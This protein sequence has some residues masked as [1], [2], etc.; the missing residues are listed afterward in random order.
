MKITG[1]HRRYVDLAKKLA[2]SSSYSLHRHGAVLVKGGSVLNWSANQNKVQR[3]AQRFRSH[4]CGHA[5]HHA[6]LGA[7]L[8]VARDKTT[9]SDVYVVRISKKGSLLMSKPCEMC[10]EL[11]RHVGVKRVFYSIDDET[12]GCYKV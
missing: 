1:R 6:E 7:V 3:W 12:M 8:G 9:G 5:T 2:E 11:L 4:G 10:Q